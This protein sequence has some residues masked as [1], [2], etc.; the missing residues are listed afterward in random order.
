MCGISAKASSSTATNSSSRKFSHLPGFKWSKEEEE[1]LCIWM[2]IQSQQKSYLPLTDQEQKELDSR[3]V[4]VGNIDVNT[5]AREIER[6]FDVCGSV[7]VRFVIDRSTG[8]Q[9]NHCFVEIENAL[10]VE[11]AFDLNGTTLNHRYITVRP[12][13][14]QKAQSEN[15]PPLRH[16]AP[17]RVYNNNTTSPYRKDNR[18]VLLN[19]HPLNQVTR[20]IPY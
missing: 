13:K 10:F 8:F 18:R 5:T 3:T 20:F 11:F 17:A 4:F 12:K 7:K 14:S 6:H 16:V 19:R 2:R 1:E 9:K 15:Q